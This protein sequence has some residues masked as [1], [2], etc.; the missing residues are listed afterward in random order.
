MNKNKN[1]TNLKEKKYFLSLSRIQNPKLMTGIR[2]ENI[3]QFDMANV[4]D[5]DKTD[6]SDM[7]DT[8]TL[9]SAVS[10]LSS[11]ASETL[12]FNTIKNKNLL[13]DYEKI[14]FKKF[15]S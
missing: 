9:A 10:T 4:K 3:G 13:K 6:F 5:K 12:E 2:N 15:R 1:T 14:R 7:I 11:L 8:L